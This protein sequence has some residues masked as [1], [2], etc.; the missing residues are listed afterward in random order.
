MLEAEN[1]NSDCWLSAPKCMHILHGCC[2]RTL[3]PEDCEED[4]TGMSLQ[5]VGDI[6]RMATMGLA[7]LG[8][9]GRVRVF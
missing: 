2:G 3:P 9:K 7:A 5:V 4:D 8:E 1:K 6:E